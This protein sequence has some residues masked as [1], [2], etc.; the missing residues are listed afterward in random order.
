MHH[1]TSG[2]SAQVYLAALCLWQCE[3]TQRTV[4]RRQTSRCLHSPNAVAVWWLWR[5]VPLR[6]RPH[7]AGWR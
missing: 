7:L 6:M 2:G 5:G 3:A 1:F 4:H